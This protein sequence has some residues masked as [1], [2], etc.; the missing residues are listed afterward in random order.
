M[1]SLYQQCRTEHAFFL[2]IEKSTVFYIY[3]GL[4]VFCFAHTEGK[5]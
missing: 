2:Q 3:K 4:K 1:S 5:N